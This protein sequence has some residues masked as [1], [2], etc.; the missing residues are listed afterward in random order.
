[1]L[2]RMGEGLADRAL[3]DLVEGDPVRLRGGDVGRLGDVPGDRLALAVEVGGEEDVVGPAGGL[4]DRRDLLAPVLRD[5]VL[6]LE[7]VVDVDAELALARVLGQVADVAVRGEDLVVLAEVALDRPRL[8]GRLHDHEVLRHGGRECSTGPFRRYRF[9]RRPARGPTGQMSRTRCRKSSSISR[10]RSASSS[11]PG[12][13]CR[14]A[15]G[16]RSVLPAASRRPAAASLVAASPPSSVVG[17]SRG[18]GPATRRPTRGAPPSR[19]RGSR[20]TGH[21]VREEEGRADGVDEHRPLAVHQRRL[22]HTARRR[23]RRAARTGR[24]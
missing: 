3:G 11:G 20:G 2:A 23:P 10:S 13:G 4:L 5:D 7:V 9:R 18:L 21:V 16:E 1:M 12:S 8:G 17:P 15:T 24:P 19:P 14:R 6:G 22:V